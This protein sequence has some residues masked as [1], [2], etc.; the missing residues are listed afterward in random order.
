M[1]INPNGGTKA[2]MDDKKKERVNERRE[3][4]DE[5]K[6][7]INRTALKLVWC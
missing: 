2:C 4:R 7:Q 6:D 3:T 5:Y 1:E